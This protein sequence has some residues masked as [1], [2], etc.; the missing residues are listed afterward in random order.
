MF[1]FI[2]SVVGVI[3]FI[4]FHIA[5]F[6]YVILIVMAVVAFGLITGSAEKRIEVIDKQIDEDLERLKATSEIIKVNFDNCEFQDSSYSHKIVDQRFS[7]GGISDETTRT[8][9]VGQSLLTYHYSNDGRVEKFMQA[10]PV[11]SDALKFY[12][13]NGDVTLY[14]DPFNRSRYFFDLKT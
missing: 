12:V 4:Y 13:L 11:V 2:A 8:E 3:F 6:W 5:L 7:H 14:V 1:L 9:N 10:F